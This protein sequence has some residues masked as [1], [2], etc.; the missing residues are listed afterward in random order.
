MRLGSVPQALAKATG[1]VGAAAPLGVALT[2]AARASP[3]VVPVV[4][5]MKSRRVVCF[6][7]F[8]LLRWSDPPGDRSGGGRLLDLTSLRHLLLLGL[9]LLGRRAERGWGIAVGVSGG[10]AGTFN[11]ARRR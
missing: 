5:R 2:P 6:A 10:S 8:Y 11:S 4:S 1:G 7:M 3:T 9:L